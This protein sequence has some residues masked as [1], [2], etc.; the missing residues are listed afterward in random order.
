MPHIVNRV[1]GGTNLGTPQ[2]SELRNPRDGGRAA[3][4]DAAVLAANQLRGAVAQPERVANS[5]KW[6][7]LLSKRPEEIA[8][9]S[10]EGVLNALKKDVLFLANK[11][12]KPDENAEFVKNLNKFSERTLPVAEK[13]GTLLQVFRLIT[14]EGKVPEAD[15]L[16]LARKVVQNAALPNRIDQGFHN[17]CNVT[18][19]ET[20]MYT[21][22]PSLAAGIVADLAINNSFTAANGRAISLHS[23]EKDSEALLYRFDDGTRN[24]ASQLFQLAAVNVYWSNQDIMPDGRFAG[25]GNIR[26]CQ[27]SR[28]GGGTGEYIENVGTNPPTR[29]TL[30][31]GD[32]DGPQLDVDEL[33]FINTQLTGQQEDDFIIERNGFSKK[34]GVL[35]VESSADLRATLTR[36]KNENKFPCL[37]VVDAAMPP[38]G[39]V[40]RQNSSFGRHAVTVTDYDAR[41]DAISIDNQYG[42]KQDIT[43]NASEK[44]CTDS[45][46]LYDAMRSRPPLGH[47]WENVKKNVANIDWKDCS[48]ATLAGCSTTALLQTAFRSHALTSTVAG[49]RGAVI[50]VERGPLARMAWRG[51]STLA[52]A[53]LVVGVNDLDKAFRDG[54]E[55]GFGVTGRLAMTALGYELGFGIATDLLAKTGTKWMPAKV[56]VPVM[57]GIACATT[58]DVAVGECFENIFRTGYRRVASSIRGSEDS[59]TL[60]TVKHLG[61]DFRR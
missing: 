59:S 7:D 51:G 55:H 1:M 13:C 43:G 60:G 3:Q 45:H 28:T 30:K 46:T 61:A 33:V 23:L 16:L 5:A 34:K 8:A 24:Y 53:A 11:H 32:A 42:S 47:V 21:R 41:R 22:R 25:K 29:Y 38:F 35:S 58:Y 9:A 15:R 52:A 54:P 39:S 10:S 49:P 50:A 48:K 18:S 17:T 4:G 19:L 44:A 26:Y 20:R 12:M 2:M 57:A 36:L 37:L 56:A 31:H 6:I 14:V 27:G 40:D